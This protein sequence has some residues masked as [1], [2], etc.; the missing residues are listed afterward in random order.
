[1]RLIDAGAVVKAIVNERNKIDVS[2]IEQDSFGVSG[3]SMRYGI[4][5]A[6]RCIE[7]APTIDAKRVKHGKWVDTK[8][9]VCNYVACKIEERCSRCGRIVYRLADQLPNNYCPS[10]GASMDL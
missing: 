1:M 3:M 5:K 10:C 9:F 7:E 6:L 2:T 4:K 8:M